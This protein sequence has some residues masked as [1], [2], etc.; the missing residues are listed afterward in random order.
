MRIINRDDRPPTLHGSRPGRVFGL[1]DPRDEDF[2]MARRTG[3][4]PPHEMEPALEHLQ[5]LWD[6]IQASQESHH[7]RVRPGRR[8]PHVEASN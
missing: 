3:V 7:D 8:N 6:E 2:V 5:L 1:S 4:R